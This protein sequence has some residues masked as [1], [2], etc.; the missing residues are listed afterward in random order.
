MERSYG[1]IHCAI[2]HLHNNHIQRVILDKWDAK[3]GATFYKT[4]PEA[5]FAACQWILDNK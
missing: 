2:S 4:E 3:D 1:H 5:V